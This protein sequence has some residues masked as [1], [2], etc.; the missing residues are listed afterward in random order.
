MAFQ[1]QRHIYWT[2]LQICPDK[3]DNIVTNRYDHWEKHRGY[4][5]TQ[6]KRWFRAQYPHHKLIVEELDTVNIIYVL[7]KILF[8]SMTNFH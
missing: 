3:I 5:S 4:S 1:A 2:Q 6:I 8:D 7:K